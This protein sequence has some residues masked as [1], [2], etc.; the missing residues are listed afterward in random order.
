MVTQ[1]VV[2]SG[3]KR[4]RVMS[5]GTT[6]AKYLDTK[7]EIKLDLPTDSVLMIFWFS[8]SDKVARDTGGDGR[9]CVGKRYKSE[10]KNMNFKSATVPKY[11]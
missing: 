8:M 3:G 7:V 11:A 2:G 9:F 5:A 1:C 10:I 4:T 6:S